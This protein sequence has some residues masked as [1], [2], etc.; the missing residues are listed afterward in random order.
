V[1]AASW[2]LNSLAYG[3]AKS[4]DDVVSQLTRARIKAT[5][6]EVETRLLELAEEQRVE[7]VGQGWRRK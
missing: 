5:R 4:A 7:A 3:Y 2:V 1:I 6:E